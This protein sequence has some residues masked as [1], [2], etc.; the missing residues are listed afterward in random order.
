MHLLSRITP[1]AAACGL[2]VTASIPS[3][4][5]FRQNYPTEM[6]VGTGRFEQ[7]EFP[8]TSSPAR[9]YSVRGTSG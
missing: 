3:W 6:T 4:F 9:E 5:G 8:S 2:R 1:N 7:R